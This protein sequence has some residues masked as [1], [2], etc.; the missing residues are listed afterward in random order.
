[1]AYVNAIFAALENGKTHLNA[2]RAPYIIDR[3]ICIYVSVYGKQW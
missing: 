2:M 1:M 3:K